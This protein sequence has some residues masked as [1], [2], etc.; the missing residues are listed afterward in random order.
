VLYVSG[1]TDSTIL[2]HGMLEPGITLL[3]KPFTSGALVRKVRELL[4][5]GHK[6]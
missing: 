1:Y 2:R 3:Q 5:R 4:D 6:A